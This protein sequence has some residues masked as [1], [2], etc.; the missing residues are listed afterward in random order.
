MFFVASIGMAAAQGP[1]KIA[2]VQPVQPANGCAYFEVQGG[3]PGAW[4]AISVG[5]AAFNSEFGFLLSAYYSGAAVT[6]NTAGMACG[7][8]KIQWVYI[9]TLN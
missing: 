1:V 5:D 8:P 6:F 9:G 2:A 7:Y 4:Y 3:A